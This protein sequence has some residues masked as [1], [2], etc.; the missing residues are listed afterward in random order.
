[1]KLIVKK[2]TIKQKILLEAIEWF[3][4]A[5]GYSPTIRELCVLVGNKSTDTVFN[6]LLQLE[7]KGYIST[8]NGKIRTIKVLKRVEEGKL[9]EK[10]ML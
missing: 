9:K 4:D 1:M 8:S 2:L 10:D 3:I 5:N 6:K 7:Q